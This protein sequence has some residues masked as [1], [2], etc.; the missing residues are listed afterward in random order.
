MAKLTV[1]QTVKPNMRGA[2]ADH[3]AHNLR[4]TVLDTLDTVPAQVLVKC[5]YEALGAEPLQAYWDNQSAV[6]TI[7]REA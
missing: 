2:R 4:G 3:W 6:E 1:G 7:G 5:D